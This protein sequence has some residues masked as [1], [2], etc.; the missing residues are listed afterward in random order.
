MGQNETNVMYCARLKSLLSMYVESRGVDSI[1]V[2]LS[3]TVS[4][5]IKSTL[6]ENCLRYVL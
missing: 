5:R 2:L 6:S 4:D 1:D 3:L